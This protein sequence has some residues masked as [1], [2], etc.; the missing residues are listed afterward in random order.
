MSE[1]ENNVVRDYGTDVNFINLDER[2]I[3]II[4]TAHISR[5]SA[6]TVREV[7]EN[8]KPDTVCIELDAQRYKALSEKKRW[9][10][11]D[12]KNLIKE[13]QLSTLIV[14]ILLSSYQKKLGEKLGV[15]P[16]TE[17]L[18]A[19]NTA[20]ENNI[21]ISL[22]DREI[23][24]TLRRAWNSM[25]FWQKI[26]LMGGGFAGIFEKQELTE[27]K[28]QEIRQK[29]VVSELMAELGK[30]MPVLK[31][32]LL[33]ER[34][35]YLAQKIYKSEGK[36]IVAV[37]GA[38]HVNGIIEA[39]NE[40]RNINLASIEIV[41]PSSPWVKIIG[42]GI[43]VIIV[44]SILLIGYYKGLG[45]AS[46]NSL[47]WFLANGIPSAIGAM[48]A[49]AHPITIIAVFFAAPFTSLTPVIGA[50]YVAAFIQ[51]YYR[52]PVVKEIQNVADD[53]NKPVMWWK[54]KLLRVI[55][56]FILSSLGSVLGT[57]LGAYK[58]IS[59]L[60]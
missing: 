38:G 26:K 33:D 9:E 53:V 28:L 19:A 24:I 34:D 4:G 58:I 7:I 11:L 14:N 46:D 50:G 17:L 1:A 31:R 16:G 36:K 45:A 18:E 15:M 44:A 48:I 35:T 49:F 39:I 5:Q 2:E 12:L 22:C 30:S 23:R 13:K 52:P 47:Y 57:Y 32:V 41:P 20:K 25:S 54:N 51:A 3:I 43:P 29:D 60:F 40:K 6:D 55:F 21:P 10:S 59:S 56:V 37:V 42:W 8:E 27:E